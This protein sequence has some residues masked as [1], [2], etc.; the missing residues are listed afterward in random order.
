MRDTLAILFAHG[1]ELL[2]DSPVLL[3]P[4]FCVTYGLLSLYA[5]GY[6]RQNQLTFHVL[7]LFIF[8][9]F[10]SIWN[11]VADYIS[12]VLN[13]CVALYS[14]V[15]NFQISL[16]DHHTICRLRLLFFD[17]RENVLFFAFFG[18]VQ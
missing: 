11:N 15:H 9:V 17:M 2:I 8:L 1:V 16:V 13:K 18:A 6:V 7:F 14:C 3:D 5:P 10:Q 12:I 4:L